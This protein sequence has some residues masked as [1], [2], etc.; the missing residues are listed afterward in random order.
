MTD[1]HVIDKILFLYKPETLNTR[2]ILFKG[3]RGGGKSWGIAEWLINEM[4]G[5]EKQDLLCVRE[6]QKS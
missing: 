2:F 5:L 4:D 6:V 1:I 3:G